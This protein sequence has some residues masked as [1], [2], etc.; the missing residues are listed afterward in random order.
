MPYHQWLDNSYNWWFCRGISGS[1]D[2]WRCAP[3]KFLS[4]TVWVVTSR[5][6]LL[7]ALC[8]LLYSF[9]EITQ[10]NSDT[11]NTRIL[12]SLWTHIHKSY[13]YKHLR[14]LSRQILV[15]KEVTIDASM[16]M[17][18]SPTTECTIP[19]NL[20]L[21]APR[22]VEPR[23]SGAA[24]ALVTTRLHAL[25]RELL[26]SERPKLLSNWLEGEVPSPLRN[27]GKLLI[28]RTRFLWGGDCNI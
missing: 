1:F 7:F 21:F 18:M 25:S 26:Y 4:K 24:E 27:P 28:S 17:G 3:V 14:R 20:R 12:T 6:I 2:G 10:Y 19:L 8:E 5:C 15:I 22:G 9:F 13:L 16:L 23:T 11:H